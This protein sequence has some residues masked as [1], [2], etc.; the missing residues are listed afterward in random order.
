MKCAQNR[1]LI[2]ISLV[3]IL[4]LLLGCVSQS[5]MS[6]FTFQ[7]HRPA[8]F[9]LGVVVFGDEQ[10][11][12]VS[13]LS[14]RYIVDAEGN[15]RASIGDGSNA[16]TYPKITRRLSSEDLDRI[17]TSIEELELGDPITYR[18]SLDSG[19]LIEIRAT[20]TIRVWESNQESAA[21]F[22]NLLADLAW[23]GE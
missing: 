14:A 7:D 2:L 1:I 21:G 17:W 9:T 12:E 5:S 16:G 4:Q 22:V 20:H 23:I 10:A 6:N 8:D 18:G 3:A 15:L 19:Y 13:N 11:R